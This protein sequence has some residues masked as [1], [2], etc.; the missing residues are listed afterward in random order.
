MQNIANQRKGR[1]EYSECHKKI[2]FTW[3]LLSGMLAVSSEASDQLQ[4]DQVLPLNYRHHDL[5]S[6]AQKHEEHKLATAQM[7]H[8]SQA[9]SLRV[10]TKHTNKMNIIF[11]TINMQT[12]EHSHRHTHEGCS[13]TQAIKFDIFGPP[14]KNL[15]ATASYACSSKV[16]VTAAQA[17]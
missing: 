7:T 16:F 5:S 9:A 11:H 17:Q 3:Q 2:K 13:T 14:S 1:N 6:S 15:R 12:Y 4:T 10:L 8:S